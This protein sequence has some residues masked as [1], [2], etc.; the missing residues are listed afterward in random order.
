MVENTSME[1][2]KKRCQQAEAALK[3]IEDRNR[4]L[5]DSA[6]FGIFTTDPKGHITGHEQQ[7]AGDALMA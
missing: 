1:E 3:E 5:G 6:P 7:N 2:L 4:L